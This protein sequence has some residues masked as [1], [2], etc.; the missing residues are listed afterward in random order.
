MCVCVCVCVVC[1]C[2]VYMC[3]C[4][5]FMCVCVCVCVCEQASVYRPVAINLYFFLFIAVL[6]R[7]SSAN[8]TSPAGVSVVSI[9]PTS[10]RTE[11]KHC[12]PA[13]LIG[14]ESGDTSTALAPR[15]Q[16]GPRL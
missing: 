14:D 13:Q 11:S 7:P 1:V 16:H 2:Y 8:A 3:V 12:S 4:F 10:E 9:E 15:V 6:N 5:V